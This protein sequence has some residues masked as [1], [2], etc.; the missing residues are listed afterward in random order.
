MVETTKD[1]LKIAVPETD[2][3][4][5]GTYFVSN[6]PPFS[7]W[8]REHVPAVETVLDRQANADLPVGLY[9]HI[10][11]CRKRCKFCYFRVLTDKNSSE[12][13]SYTGALAKEMA[14]YADRAVLS[15]RA[16]KFVYF[17][18]GT[19]S[20]LSA[21]QLLSLVEKLRASVS[22]DDA[23]EVTFECEPGTLNRSKVDALKQ[24]GVTR[25]SLGAENLNDAL[26]RE[27][28]RAHLSADILRAYEWIR[29]AD[30]P[31]V[32]ID[33]ISGMAGE[34]QENWDDCVRRTIELAPDSVTIYQMELPYNTVYSREILIE[35][36]PTPIAG[37]RQK[38]TWVREAF[39]AFEAAGYHVSS[40][41]TVVK[42]SKAC[43]FSYRD[44]LWHGADMI[45]MGVSSFSHVGGVHYQNL[46]LFEAYLSAIEEGRLPVQRAFPMRA[47]ERVIRELIL[48]M[49]LGRVDAGYFRDKFGREVLDDFS[50]AF[51]SLKEGG[52][53][54]WAGDDIEL[55]RDGLLKIDEMLPNFFLPEHRN[56]RTT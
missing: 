50:G 21:A 49:K 17:G 1:A 40:A 37:W 33:L 48:Q 9:L 18:G 28:G 26:L 44:S 46:D 4:N 38:R 25:V 47:A 52:V 45:G 11:F 3:T 6:Y 15:N 27:N 19:P 16:L 13:E 7:L 51:G 20:F 41:Y 53:L 24:I 29:A 55:T 39:A 23:E 5:V 31:Y 30:F 42:N 2:E 10:P 43:N 12:V 36:K 8:N 56:V 34:T 35:G 22:W 14:L 54:D 32:N